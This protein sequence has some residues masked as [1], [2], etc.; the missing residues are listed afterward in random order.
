MSSQ[1]VERIV[2]VVGHAAQDLW[3]Q[4]SYAEASR[5]S[6]LSDSRDW[7]EICRQ[8]HLDLQL[9]PSVDLSVIDQSRSCI[10]NSYHSRR[11]PHNWSIFA[12]QI[13]YP[14]M[15]SR[16]QSVDDEACSRV[17]SIPWSRNM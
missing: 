9:L 10:L 5:I 7:N 15:C 11:H 4:R 13:V 8:H 1:A 12:V 6:V 14:Y 2:D 3:W 17:F 16:Y